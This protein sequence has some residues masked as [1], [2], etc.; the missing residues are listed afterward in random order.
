MEGSKKVII[1][2]LT[3]LVLLIGGGVGYA[4]NTP[5]AR[6][7]RQLNLGNKYL[8]EGKYQEAILAFQKVIEIEPK[9]IPARLGLGQVYIATKDYDK[10]EK[11]LKEVIQIDNNNI[12]ARESLFKVYIKENKLNEANSILLE[13]TQIDPKKDVKQFNSDLASAKAINTSKASYDQGVKQMNNSQYL[14]AIVSFQKVIKE[15]TERYS[16]AQ[17]KAAECKTSFIDAALQ[18]AK[19]A[20][21]NKDYQAALVFIKQIISIDPNNQEAQKLKDEYTNSL[22]L[23]KEQQDKEKAINSSGI[24]MESAISIVTK[25]LAQKGITVEKYPK[26]HIAGVNDENGCYIIQAYSDE[27]NHTATIGWYAVQKTTGNLYDNMED[28]NHQNKLN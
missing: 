8:Q 14:A 10:A 1:I 11:V 17:K 27:G 2:V 16:D 20:A 13:M 18:K 5:T 26:I 9:N 28:F 3:V 23:I 25:Y 24:T 7:E 12:L 4:M 15:D 6:A 22:Q 19:D 21:S